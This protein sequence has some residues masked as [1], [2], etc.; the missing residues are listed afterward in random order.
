MS[1]ANN[2]CV[3][4][5]CKKGFVSRIVTIREQKEGTLP[6]RTFLV[7]FTT[8]LINNLWHISKFPSPGSYFI[9][10]TTAANTKAT[11]TFIK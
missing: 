2:M 10:H 11:S 8:A 9:P 1:I 7:M 5:Q 6:L 3:T 4:L